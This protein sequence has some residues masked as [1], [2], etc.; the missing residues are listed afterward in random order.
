MGFKWSD[1]QI[2]SPRPEGANLIDWLLRLCY[3]KVIAHPA[4]GAAPPASA[5]TG[6]SGRTIK[7]SRPD[8]KEPIDEIGSFAFVS[9]VPSRT[10]ARGFALQARRSDFYGMYQ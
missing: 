3:P 1:V 8:Q 7:S 5:L 2:V 4:S 6:S 9:L 10:P